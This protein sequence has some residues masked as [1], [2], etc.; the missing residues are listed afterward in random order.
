[1]WTDCRALTPFVT[2]DIRSLREIHNNDSMDTRNVAYWICQIAGWGI[3]S[4][5]GL[6]TGVMDHGLRPSVTI[7]Y[8]L[9]FLYSIG[10]THGLRSHIRRHHW[11]SLPPYQALLRLVPASAAMAAI[12]SGLVV[13]IYTLLEGGMGIWREYSAIFYMF[14]G[15]TVFDTI[16]CVLYLAIV[17]FRQ[18]HEMRE[19][20]LRMQLA[21]SNAE[22]CALEAQVNPHFLFNCLNSIRGMISEDTSVAQ[23]MVTRLAN[24]LRHNLQ[25]DRKHTVKLADEIDA[26]TDYLALEKVRF[27]DRLRV[28]LE[29]DE[30]LR[31]V[32]IPSML[33]QTL[34]ENAIK[35]GV[36]EQAGGGDIVIRATGDKSGGFC[37]VVESAGTIAQP[38]L[39]SNGVGLVN[40]RE[41]LRI[42]YGDQASLRLD[43]SGED[44]VAATLLIP[45]TV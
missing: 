14:L 28:R 9:F 24:L 23:E 7:G 39:E 12:Q 1:V 42:L 2:N 6:T 40:A 43:Q 20:E 21:L 35:Y 31:E 45:T 44:R 32:E 25:K 38:R 22:L 30:A 10:L 27:E 19:N 29:I 26:V 4:A 15:I 11:S 17:T 13:G 8:L 37:V 18:S 41:R 5:I 16:W 36:E 3:Y 33:L 34:T